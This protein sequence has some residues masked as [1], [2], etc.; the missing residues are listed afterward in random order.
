MTSTKWQDTITYKKWFAFLYASTEQF[1]MELRKSFIV[2]LQRIK[3][4]IKDTFN[5]TIAKLILKL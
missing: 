4:K 1:E 3:Y 5:K 2:A